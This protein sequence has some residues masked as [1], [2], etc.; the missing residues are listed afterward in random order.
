MLQETLY[1]K[2]SYACAFAI[3]LQPQ[4]CR[5]DYWLIN[6]RILWQSNKT[7]MALMTIV[8][9]Q[10]KQ[11]YVNFAVL[12]TVDA[13][14]LCLLMYSWF[15][16]WYHLELSNMQN[17]IWKRQRLWPA[18]QSHWLVISATASRNRTTFAVDL[19][20]PNNSYLLHHQVIMHLLEVLDNISQWCGYLDPILI[21][22]SAGSLV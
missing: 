16:P 8:L 13:K 7:S 2:I 6:L 22:N 9:M 20:H 18:S 11:E 17:L 3:A 5:A 1:V 19:T 4:T 15:F 14:Q 12:Q 10:I 21:K